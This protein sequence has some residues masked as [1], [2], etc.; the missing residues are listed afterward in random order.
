MKRKKQSIL[1]WIKIPALLAGIT[2]LIHLL[3]FAS[4]YIP[5]SGME[6]SLFPGD[7][8]LVNKWSYG[9]RIPLSTL[10]GYHRLLEHPVEQ[11]DIV[12][13]NNP[14]PPVPSTPTGKR[15]IYIGR[16]IGTPGDTL[17]TD[18]LFLSVTSSI[19]ADPDKKNLYR[20]PVNKEKEIRELLTDLQIP[21]SELMGSA[22]SFSVRSFSHYEH[23]LL[24]QEIKGE[25][26][27]QPFVPD[28]LCH[29]P[30]IVPGKTTEITIT[31]QNIR[32][33]RN[34]LVLHE[35]VD[36][37]VINDSLY[38]EGR[39]TPTCRFTQD[40]YWMASGNSIN[41]AD[42][43]LFGLVPHDHVI[44]KGCWVWFSKRKESPMFQGYQWDRIFKPVY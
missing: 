11:G 20:Y 30:F 7:H 42:S 15:N 21:H 1:S 33:I 38:I 4:C 27:I 9:Y 8:V 25:S 40:Y 43:R 35:G 5:A 26:W 31:P 41:F 23:Y 12:L 6:N 34:T 3:F 10:W 37:E 24:E 17:Y 32:L 13:F 18:T 16:C 2:L 36:A 28:S 19:P 14:Y 22:D 44:G 29:H 39:Y